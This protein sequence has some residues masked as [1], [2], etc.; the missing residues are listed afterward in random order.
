MRR[1]GFSGGTSTRSAS[2]GSRKTSLLTNNPEALQGAGADGEQ[3][4]EP[5]RLDLGDLMTVETLVQVISSGD[6]GPAGPRRPLG[7]RGRLRSRPVYRTTYFGPVGQLRRSLSI[8]DVLPTTPTDQ[9]I[10]GGYTQETGDLDS[11]PAETGRGR[12]G[13]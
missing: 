2:A 12:A 9:N 11:G 5:G 7:S 10:V 4:R 13:T 6:W 3:P 8:L 1:D